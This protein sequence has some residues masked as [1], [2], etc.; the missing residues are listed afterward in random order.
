MHQIICDTI[1][2]DTKILKTIF[3][4]QENKI[5]LKPTH[6][7]A[8]KFS[9]FPVH[10]IHYRARHHLQPPVYAALSYACLL[11]ND[12]TLKYMFNT[13][14]RR[15]DNTNRNVSVPHSNSFRQDAE[16]VSQGNAQMVHSNRTTALGLK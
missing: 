9:S 6:H 11:L 14:V 8:M 13:A 7:I 12:R 1:S 5:Q 16:D 3:F 15:A 2:Q 4:I 10:C